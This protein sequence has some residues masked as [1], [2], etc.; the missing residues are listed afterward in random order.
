MRAVIVLACVAVCAFGATLP[1]NFNQ[2]PEQ[3]KEFVPEEVKS[4]Y[5]E[6]TEED[7][8]ILKEIAAKHAEYENE[9]Q[10]LNA[11]KEKSEKLY[12]KANNLRNL[13]KEKV[14]SLQAEAKTFVNSIIEKLR[15]LRPKGD[16]KPNLNKLRDTANE[17][18]ESYK[19][20]SDEAKENL[21]STFPKITSVIQNEK[22]QKLA[23]GLLKTEGAEN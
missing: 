17:V 13:V 2:L 23:K 3:F 1:F 20:L 16:E 18:I 5:A 4:F 15:A 14:D 12:E 10:A 11:L 9:E 22:F 6:L 19:A 7:K 8:N 21:K